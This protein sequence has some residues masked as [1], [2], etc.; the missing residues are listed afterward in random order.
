M[1]S[2]SVL[3]LLKRAR[4][5]GAHRGPHRQ[6]ARERQGLLHE[7]ATPATPHFV[8]LPRTCSPSAL[9]LRRGVA[10][11]GPRADEAAG[12][13]RLQR[14]HGG[15]PQGQRPQREYSRT[16]GGGGRLEPAAGRP[17]GEGS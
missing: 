13:A 10:R 15:D 12:P 1:Q 17:G 6:R 5:H 16:S 9:P 4:V 2:P 14:G 11:P 7:G 3:V 8:A